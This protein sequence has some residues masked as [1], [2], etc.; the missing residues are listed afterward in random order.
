MKPGR[1]K[2]IFV[3]ALVALGVLAFV[4]LRGPGGPDPCAEPPSGSATSAAAVRCAER[5]VLNE[6]YT[7][8]WGR[9][10][11]IDS[12]PMGEGTWFGLVRA[13][14]GT[15]KSELDAICTHPRDER[16]A[17]GHVALF[18][19]SAPERGPCRAFSVTPLL[20][21]SYRAQPCEVVRA[22]SHCINREAALAPP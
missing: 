11:A 14:R 12:D 6:W 18:E 16:G 13:H 4:A 8:K 9:F 22:Q 1:K 2:W 3:G 21:V 20:G 10:G 17:L 15:L 5:Y 7:T 19:P